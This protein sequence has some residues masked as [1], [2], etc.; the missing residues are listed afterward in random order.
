MSRT[1]A[2]RS[3]AHH[4]RET[5]DHHFSS[6]AGRPAS[7][8]LVKT[9]VLRRRRC[10]RA[11]TIEERAH[12]GLLAGTSTYRG[13]GCCIFRGRLSGCLCPAAL[14]VKI[15]ASTLHRGGEGEL[16]ENNAKPYGIS[17]LFSSAQENTTANYQQSGCEGFRFSGK[18]TGGSTGKFALPLTFCEIFV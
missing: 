5:L 9:F 10:E 1:V 15:F 2:R 11:R 7:I 3:N 18:F 17:F 14:W 16:M 12:S 8:C 13:F 6:I 4:P